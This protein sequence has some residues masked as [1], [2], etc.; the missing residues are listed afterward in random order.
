M[1]TVT[2]TLI[3]EGGPRPSIAFVYDDPALCSAAEWWSALARAAA[4]LLVPFSLAGIVAA[5]AG[6]GSLLGFAA[7]VAGAAVAGAA[8]RVQS[9]RRRS[10]TPLVVEA[11]GDDV[12]GPAPPAFALPRLAAAMLARA[13][14]AWPLLV[15]AGGIR[16]PEHAFL[17]AGWAPAVVTAWA[18]AGAAVTAARIRR[19]ERRH[20]GRVLFPAGARQRAHVAPVIRPAQR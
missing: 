2:G 4:A 10:R 17:A 11:G 7:S 15:L 1:D 6:G 12:A 13:W 8:V 9:G 16:T 14:I 5:A 19:L 3:S 20:G 18:A